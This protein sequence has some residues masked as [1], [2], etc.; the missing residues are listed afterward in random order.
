MPA[1]LTLFMMSN[2]IVI[3]R[4]QKIDGKQC[5]Q[6]ISWDL[7][8]GHIEEGQWLMNKQLFLKGCALSP[9]GQY[10][11]WIYNQFQS[12]TEM[13]VAGISPVPYFS[14]HYYGLSADI[15]R[16][17]VAGFADSGPVDIGVGLHRTEICPLNSPLLPVSTAEY[18]YPTGWLCD[19]NMGSVIL[20]FGTIRLDEYRIYLNDSLIY[21]GSDAKF[22]SVSPEMTFTGKRKWM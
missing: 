17:R 2:K 8:T 13:A 22:E 3:L 21:D 19:S 15:G 6:M 20:D 4:F 14:A 12:R 1:K 11:Y 5:W 16:T 18:V 7:A 9:C 10:F